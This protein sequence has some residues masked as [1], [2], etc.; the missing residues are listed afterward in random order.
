[1]FNGIGQQPLSIGK[2]ECVFLLLNV[3]GGKNI[4]DGDEWELGDRRVKPQNRRQPGR[5]KLPWTA[6]RTTGML[7]RQCPSGIAQRPPHHATVV[8][9]A[10]QNRVTKTM[11]IAPQLGN[12]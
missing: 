5:P 12:N 8:P 1:M 6:A 11:S 10:M 7:I 2:Q 3:H 4:R 9:T